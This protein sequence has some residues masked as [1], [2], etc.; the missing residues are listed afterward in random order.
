M[1]NQLAKLQAWWS[2]VS[3]REQRL[4]VACGIL[5][6][7]GVAYWGVLQP[8]NVRAEQA[9]QGIIREKQLLRW[10]ESKADNIVAL[11]SSNGVGLANQPLNQVITSSAQR[12][13]IELAR[14][15]PRE[16]MLQVWV[17]PLPFDKLL[18]WLRY[19]KETQGL[20]AE[21]MDINRGKQPGVVEVNRLQFKRG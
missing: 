12:F 1:K 6:V 4:L 16:D 20:N 21:F 9:K 8:A 19:L 5:L 17:Q 11:R 15:Q 2:S 7:I 14:V 10:V 18:D 3:Q 13:N